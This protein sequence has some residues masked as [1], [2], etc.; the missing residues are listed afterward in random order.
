VTELEATNK[1]I[2]QQNAALQWELQKSNTE[3]KV[4]HATGSRQTAS[5]PAVKADPPSPIMGP[6]KF[7]PTDFF[8]ELSTTHPDRSTTQRSWIDEKTGQRVY[9]AGALWDKISEHRLFKEG[10]IDLMELVNTL[11]PKAICD[12]HGPVFTERDIETAIEDSVLE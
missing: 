6:Q 7:T 1:S 3:I 4:L 9:G 2:T 10:N 5:P 8:A 12:G 11:K